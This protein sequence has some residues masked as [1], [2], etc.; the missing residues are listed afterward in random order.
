MKT[1]Y[2]YTQRS[3]PYSNFW[4]VK[5]NGFYDLSFFLDYDE[6]K[7]PLIIE[8]LDWEQ[9]IPKIRTNSDTRLLSIEHNMTE[10]QRL[11]FASNI[12]EEFNLKEVAPISWIKEN[13][14]LI[15]SENW[16]LIREFDPIFNIEEK[17]LVID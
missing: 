8:V 12:P 5:L 14:T 6:Y 17:Y 9:L 15:P 16:Y 4:K 3:I 7:N 2:E 1:Y 13:T 11:Y 10:E